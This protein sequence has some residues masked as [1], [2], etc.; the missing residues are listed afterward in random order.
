MGTEDIW[1][2][3]MDDPADECNVELDDETISI[4]AGNGVAQTSVVLTFAEARRVIYTLELA[5]K[6]AKEG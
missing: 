2:V 5:L 1:F 3:C 4:H 6:K